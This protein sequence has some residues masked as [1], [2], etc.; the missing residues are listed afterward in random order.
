[1]FGRKSSADHI[2]AELPGVYARLWR[3]CVVLTGRVD[4][5]DDLAQTVCLRALDKANQFTPGTHL[6]RWL[7]TLALSV[8]RNELRGRKLRQ[9]HGLIPVDEAA[10]E[11]P[12]LPAEMNIFARQVLSQI[13]ALPEAQRMAVL[14][15]YI[16]GN[17]YQHCADILG[18]PIGT[19]MSR[20]AAVRARL[21]WMQEGSEG[22]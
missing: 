5:A 9:G 8:W 6:D 20:L 12:V 16:E 7:F 15:V 11:A 21:K 19:V 13:Q 1:M 4:W 22:T 3:Y 2:R 14:L 10:L 18:I 17:S